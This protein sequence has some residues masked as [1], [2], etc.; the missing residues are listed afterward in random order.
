[1]VTWVEK[2]ALFEGFQFPKE[3]SVE[4]IRSDEQIDVLQA[5]LP[6]NLSI[7]ALYLVL[8]SAFWSLDLLWVQMG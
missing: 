3:S 5:K 7:V 1:M 4:P 2:T 6:W 8:E